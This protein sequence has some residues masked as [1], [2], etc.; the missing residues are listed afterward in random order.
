MKNCS[1]SFVDVAEI[2]WALKKDHNGIDA[3]A[4]VADDLNL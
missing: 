1:T 4:V 2:V 3:V